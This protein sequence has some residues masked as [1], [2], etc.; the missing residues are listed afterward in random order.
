M[1]DIPLNFI[2]FQSMIKLHFQS[3]NWEAIVQTSVN[4]WYMA[5]FNCRI[6]ISQSESPVQ[7]CPPKVGFSAGTTNK[8]VYRIRVVTSCCRLWL[9]I[10]F[11]NIMEASNY[12]PLTWDALMLVRFVCEQL[13]NYCGLWLW[14][15]LKLK[16]KSQITAT[17]FKGS[18]PSQASSWTIIHY[19]PSL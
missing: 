13:T 4:R 14:T 7:R 18:N 1:Y 6:Y 11:E 10:G 16:W 19:P 17:N 3:S 8:Y 9:Q 2:C 12:C 5:R 15:G